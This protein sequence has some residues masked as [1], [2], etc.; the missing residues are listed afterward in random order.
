MRR[1]GLS[2]SAELLVC[3]IT[4]TD[5]QTDRHTDRQTKTITTLGYSGES[6]TVK[7][8]NPGDEWSKFRDSVTDPRGPTAAHT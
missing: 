4:K 8:N 6:E 7:P 5:R 2:A 1:A 3:L